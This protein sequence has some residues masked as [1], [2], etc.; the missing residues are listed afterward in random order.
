M[1]FISAFFLHNL[2]QESFKRTEGFH[3]CLGVCGNDFRIVSEA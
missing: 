2:F 3:P 1:A